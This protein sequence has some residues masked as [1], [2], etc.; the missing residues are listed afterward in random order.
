MVNLEG[1][2]LLPGPSF[3]LDPNC[4]HHHEGYCLSEQRDT[5]AVAVY[6]GETRAEK[7]GERTSA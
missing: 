5:G 4:L 1:T 2:R 3:L 6:T 7:G